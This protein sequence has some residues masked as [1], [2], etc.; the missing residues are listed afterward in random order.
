VLVPGGSFY[1]VMNLKYKLP[2]PTLAEGGLRELFES[3]GAT[4][5]KAIV[6]FKSIL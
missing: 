2:G 1:M 5:K 4:V 6:H 3:R